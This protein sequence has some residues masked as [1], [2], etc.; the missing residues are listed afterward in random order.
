MT[1][2]HQHVH[3][4]RYVI[5][6]CNHIFLGRSLLGECITSVSQMQTNIGVRFALTHPSKLSSSSSSTPPSGYIRFHHAELC[7]RSTHGILYYRS[8][9]VIDI[10]HPSFDKLTSCI[11]CLYLCGIHLPKKGM[12]KTTL[13]NT[14]IEVYA[15][16]P[17]GGWKQPAGQYMN[18]TIIINVLP[19]VLH[20]LHTSRVSVMCMLYDR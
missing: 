19:C 18:V 17:D 3:N 4:I 1:C 10:T 5:L 9:N 2:Q 13:P 15:W 11:I 6:S 8:P 14:Q 16:L 20:V 7:V 12:W